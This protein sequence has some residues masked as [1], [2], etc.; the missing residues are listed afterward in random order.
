MTTM[1]TSTPATQPPSYPTTTEPGISNPTRSPCPRS[2]RRYWVTMT[3]MAEGV[4]GSPRRV[5]RVCRPRLGSRSRR[6]SGRAYQ[7]T[8][9]LPYARQLVWR[10]LV[11]TRRP[12][13]GRIRSRR[14]NSLST[15]NTS[16]PPHIHHHHRPTPSYPP[17][18]CP[19]PTHHHHPSPLLPTHSPTR[20]TPPSSL[21]LNNRQ[22]Q[23]Q[24]HPCNGN[25][26]TTRT[27]WASLDP[28]A[29][30]SMC[31]DRRRP[32]QSRGF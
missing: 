8:R 23:Q 27:S 28:T 10:S 16:Q 18:N 5:R 2:R 1:M 32:G 30:D 11:D 3:T 24:P 7:P 20:S 9:R 12:R 22:Q 31:W 21:P 4:P 29:P 14:C 13:L 26:N 17:P 25:T 6:R 19:G 15:H